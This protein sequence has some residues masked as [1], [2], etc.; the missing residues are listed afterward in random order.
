M[1]GHIAHGINALH[2]TQHFGRLIIDLLTAPK[3]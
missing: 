2:N 3:L 1:M